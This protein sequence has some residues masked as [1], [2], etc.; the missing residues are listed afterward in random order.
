VGSSPRLHGWE[1]HAE[2]ANGRSVLKIHIPHSTISVFAGPKRSGD[3]LPTV[4]LDEQRS[5]SRH[6][7]ETENDGAEREARGGPHTAIQP[8]I[9]LISWRCR[10]LL[11]W[12][13]IMP[14]AFLRGD[15]KMILLVTFDFY[16]K[17]T[18]A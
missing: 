10:S 3:P 11:D 15:R 17:D 8:E 14:R 16:R 18:E 6:E 12:G 13:D 5:T 4:E 2:R 9:T 7:N 1:T